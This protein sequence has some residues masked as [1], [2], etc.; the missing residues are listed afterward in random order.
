MNYFIYL[1]EVLEQPGSK[2][3]KH[4]IVATPEWRHP[5]VDKQ[6]TWLADVDITPPRG[7]V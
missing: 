3:H 7:A 4:N 2:T 1:T 5:N 6:R